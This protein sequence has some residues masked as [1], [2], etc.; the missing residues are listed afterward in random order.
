MPAPPAGRPDGQ[1][2][3]SSP[4]SLSSKRPERR[5]FRDHAL[6]RAQATAPAN[7]LFLMTA[8]TPQLPSTTWVMPKSTAI[9][10]SEIALS[11][12][13]GCR[14][15]PREQTVYLFVQFDD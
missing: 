15:T 6:K 7:R 1:A 2:R 11:S 12:G 14:S 10:V 3:G 13:C 8:R 4:D 5:P 9:D